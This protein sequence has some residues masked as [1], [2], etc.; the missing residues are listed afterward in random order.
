MRNS[1]W[2]I[3]VLFLFSSGSYAVNPPS[4]ISHPPA[5]SESE[6]DALIRNLDADFST[7]QRTAEMIEDLASD[8]LP[9]LE[10][11][12]KE[13]KLSLEAKDL[14]TRS[15]GPVRAR[16]KMQ[17]DIDAMWAWAKTDIIDIYEKTSRHDPRWAAAAR[18]AIE[19]LATD[20]GALYP[21]DPRKMD[22]R[23]FQAACQRAIG[24]GCD[25]PLVVFAA[26]RADDI[27]RAMPGT[28]QKRYAEIAPRLRAAKQSPAM[29]ATALEMAVA[30]RLNALKRERKPVEHEAKQL[31][32]L[33]DDAIAL[34]GE[35][36]AAPTMDRRKLAEMVGQLGE[37]HKRLDPDEMHFLDKIGPVLDRSMPGKSYP[38]SYRA[39]SWL[40]Y[41]WD[42]CTDD[43][44]PQ[45]VPLT[46]ERMQVARKHAMKA[47]AIDPTDP[48]VPMVMMDSTR[49][50][51][52]D[53][54]EIRLWLDRALANDP[55]DYEV[56]SLML[57][58]LAPENGGSVE[59]VLE[60]AEQ[61]VL[62]RNYDAR[63]PLLLMSAHIRRS[64]WTFMGNTS[65]VH[66]DYFASQPEVWRSIEPV[67]KRHLARMPY[68][69]H[70][71][72]VFTSVAFYS[73][74]WSEAA[75]QMKL[76][77]PTGLPELE[78]VMR[79]RLPVYRERMEAALRTKPKG[80]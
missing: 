25:H 57:E 51:S 61:M 79:S 16:A 22:G 35:A 23:K 11:R 70:D 74:Q 59:Q 66:P 54:R 39:L 21:I 13:G 15:I 6:I 38:H 44:P 68:A 17:A 12:L 8:A 49:A 67:L 50:T 78:R 76:L 53:P 30:Y 73:E 71:R 7:R 1:V 33:L 28:L 77:G 56:C 20:Q 10:R 18:E 62:T 63:L 32:K 9:L 43:V 48:F 46:Q 69:T 27:C 41:A 36:A 31:L 72:A 55:N 2:S 52:N 14:L 5:P 3:L 65:Q 40:V 64:Y 34:T 19:W 60:F 42:A 47:Y 26:V 37:T 29:C 4:S 45:S 58:C 80:K 75:E 24:A